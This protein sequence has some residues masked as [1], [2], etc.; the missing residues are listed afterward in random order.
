MLFKTRG[1]VF[2]H[3]DYSESSVIVKIYTEAFGLKSYLL[4]GVKRSKSKIKT[5]IL[6]HL[7]IVD[8][9][10]YN[11]EK[12]GLQHI[13]EIK[14]NYKFSTIPFDIRKSSVMLFINEI[15]YRSITEESQN[16]HLFEFIY[17]S[18]IRLD[19]ETA[20]ISDFHIHFIIRLTGY[21]GFYPNNNYSETNNF[22]DL[23]EGIFQPFFSDELNCLSDEISN[24]LS[25]ILT[26]GFGEYTIPNKSRKELLNK[27]IEYYQYHISGMNEI[28]SHKVLE[29]IFN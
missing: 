12:G 5:G 4:K 2:H 20:S 24:Q 18:V 19:Q 9:V 27:I 14:N 17:G 23:R 29:E 22:F 15:L 28:N 3:F 26:K 16:K 10:V 21:L 1:I 25:V 8:L 6:Q 13:Q 7:S 11:N